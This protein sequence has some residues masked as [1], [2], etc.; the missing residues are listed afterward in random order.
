M[1]ARRNHRGALVLLGALAAA[2]LLPSTAAASKADAFEGK[3][4]PV[5]GQ[6]YRKAGRFELTLGGAMSLNDAFF[7]KYMGDAK[8]GYHL[9]DWLSVSVH[10]AYGMARPTDSTT[11]CPTG[12]GCRDATDAELWQVP[13]R[14][15]GLFGAEVAWS[16]IYGKLNVFSEKVGH[17]DLSVMA[18]VDYILHDE[19]LSSL[20]AAQLEGAGDEPAQLQTLGF[21]VGVGMRLFLARYLA[22][23]V[24][25]KDYVYGV[26]VPNGED[27]IEGNRDF[28][29]QLMTEIGLSVF[30]PLSNRRQP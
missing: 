18:G 21:H 28:Q 19:V 23:R 1:T 4:Q 24:E 27:A 6:L 29:N 2:A 11:V 16:P 12:E 10:G 13:G 5:S 3:I 14:I 20:E 22:L 8:L 26:D 30:F 7:N 9:F 17:I 25:L 15:A